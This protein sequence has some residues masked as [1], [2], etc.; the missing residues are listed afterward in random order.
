MTQKFSAARKR[1]FLNH[2][3]NSGNQTLSAERAKVSRSWVQL[4]RSTDPEFDAA[5]RE[6]IEVAKMMLRDDAEGRP[7]PP[8]LRGSSLS[9]GRGASSGRQPV[10]ARWRYMDGHELVVSG[11]NGRRTQIRRAKLTQW[12][13]RVEDRFVAVLAATC[14]VK[15]AC[16][17][18][19]MWPPSAYN[20]RKRWPNFAR[21]WDQAIEIG[22]ARLEAALIQNACHFLNPIDAPA[23]EHL[24]EGMSVSHAIDIAQMN[25]GRARALR[26]WNEEKG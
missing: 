15:L 7:L 11:T 3:A 21:R 14:N 25:C 4:H 16:R 17:E 22:Y 26:R 2:L 1:A 8:P 12:T 5:C 13:P 10:D 19:G 18:V 24:L 23:P 20:H 6:A 9:Q